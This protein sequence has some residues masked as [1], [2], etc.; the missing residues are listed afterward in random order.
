VD[1][2]CGIVDDSRYPPLGRRGFGPRVPSNYGRWGGEEYIEDSNKNVFVAVMIETREAFE[3]IEQI[4][5]IPGLDSIVIG[6]ADLTIAL[7]EKRNLRSPVVDA[8]IK[9]ITAAA[10]AAGKYIGAGMGVDVDFALY[11]AGYG[12]QWLQVGQ[13]FD[14]LVQQFDSTRLSFQERWK[15]L[16]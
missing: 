12:V 10:L 11:L 1:E 16:A 9:K 13:D 3:A 2:V 5:S 6:P 14:H 15:G 7:G 8:A 4:V